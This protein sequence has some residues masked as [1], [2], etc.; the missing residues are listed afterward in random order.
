MGGERR[1]ARQRQGGAVHTGKH[2]HVTF[3]IENGA[4]QRQELANGHLH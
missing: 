3:F 1:R 4:R 2:I